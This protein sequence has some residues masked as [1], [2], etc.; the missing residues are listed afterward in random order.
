[1]TLNFA[2]KANK[3][4]WLVLTF[5]PKGNSLG[6]I[7]IKFLFHEQSLKSFKSVRVYLFS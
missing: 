3:L 1:M 4:L 2:W 5:L 7:N 6:P